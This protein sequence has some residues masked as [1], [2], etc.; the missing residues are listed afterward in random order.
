MCKIN[1]ARYSWS[2]KYKDG[3]LN[4]TSRSSV[5]LPMKKK[6][7]VLSLK[8]LSRQVD[9]IQAKYGMPSCQP[10]SIMIAS[11]DTVYVEDKAIPSSK[12]SSKSRRY[13]RKKRHVV[14]IPRPIIVKH[15]VHNVHNDPQQC[16]QPH[17]QLLFSNHAS[18]LSSSNDSENYSA[19]VDESS[20]T[21]T[22]TMEDTA[23]TEFNL[24]DVK[25][26]D[27][28][29][30]AD[31]VNEHSDD[32]VPSIGLD[33]LASTHR[34]L[35][36]ENGDEMVDTCED[37]PDAIYHDVVIET[38]ASSD[39]DI[40]IHDYGSLDYGIEDRDALSQEEACDVHAYDC[41]FPEYAED[42]EEECM[43]GY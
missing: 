2:N 1:H 27:G 41:D 12:L 25:E 16:L 18:N 21:D 32:M 24:G 23:V 37:E 6:N 42:F 14:F 38:G 40:E 9:L 3:V 7:E 5:D 33:E 26:E 15:P 19:D 28:H 22:A 30:D 10:S 11:A 35:I 36:Y 43:Y 17:Q 29:E 4:E 39:H 13:N 20:D 34:S 31:T 8:K